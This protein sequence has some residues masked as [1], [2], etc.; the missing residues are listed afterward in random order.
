[1]ILSI[2]AMDFTPGTGVFRN[3]LGITKTVTESQKT[4]RTSSLAQRRMFTATAYAQTVR[5]GR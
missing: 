2:D 3:F 1:M 4:Q 5:C